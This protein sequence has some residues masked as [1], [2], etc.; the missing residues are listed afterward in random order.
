VAVSG[1]C[2]YFSL[3][4][5]YVWHNPALLKHPEDADCKKLPPNERANRGQRSITMLKGFLK[6]YIEIF[7]TLHMVFPGIFLKL[8]SWRLTNLKEIKVKKIN[9]KERTNDIQI[10]TTQNCVPFTSVFIA[11]GIS[12]IVE[13]KCHVQNNLT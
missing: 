10:S 6:K 8:I 9:H 5:D 12:S 1:S 4:E 2:F 7:V 11:L 13:D 3:E